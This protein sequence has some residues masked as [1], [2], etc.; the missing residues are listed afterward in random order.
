MKLQAWDPDI[1]SL[2]DRI[3]NEDIDLQPD[4]QRQE[5]WARGKQ[6]KLVD[7]ILREWSIP[8]VHLVVTANNTLEVLDGQ[9]R[10]AAIRDFLNDEIRVDGGV[11]PRDPV[12]AALHNKKYSQLP[13]DVRRRVDQYTLRA[14]RIFEYSPEEPSELFYRLNQPTGLTA[15]EKRNSLYGRSR[16]QLKDLVELF[17]SLGNNRETLGFSNARMSYDDILARLLYFLDRKTIGVKATE[18]AI[19]DRFRDEQGFSD[20]VVERA[21]DAVSAFSVRREDASAK[22]NKAS[23]LSWLIFFCRPGAKSTHVSFLRDFDQTDALVDFDRPALASVAK[24]LFSDRSSLRVTDVSSVV[25]RDFCLWLAYD[26]LYG[27]PHETG[28][29]NWLLVIKGSLSKLNRRSLE[30]SLD[31]HLPSSNWP[32]LQ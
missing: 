32:E 7:T 19:S 27:L 12:I 8:P 6:R 5:V 31:A 10:L 13:V 20:D 3:N 4:F 11:A 14:F 9:Q 23:L 26:A 28:L 21:R 16:T 29:N 30:V 15:G 1:R 22:L 24:A 18:A 17:L 2:V 25:Y